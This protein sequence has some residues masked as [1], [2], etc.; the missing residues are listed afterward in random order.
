MASALAGQN[1]PQVTAMHAKGAGGSH[2]SSEPRRRIFLSF[3][4]VARYNHGS[5][6]QQPAIESTKKLQN[7]D[8]FGERLR[9][10]R[11][12]MDLSMEDFGAIIGYDKSYLSRLESGK[13]QSPSAKF[14]EAIC[15][16]YFISREWLV[17]GEGKLLPAELLE[18]ARAHRPSWAAKAMEAAEDELSTVEVLR[19]IIRDMSTLERVTKCVEILEHPAIKPGAK[20]VW[21]KALLRAAVD[22]VVKG[23]PRQATATGAQGA[24]AL[25]GDAIRKAVK[26]S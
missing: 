13:A 4:R 24:Q 3:W 9:W 23:A 10:L 21:L 25:S 26:T 1:P 5:N 22:P 6:M 15:S 11:Q 17:Q 14:I 16:K 20:S 7:K 12:T 8:A 19:L 2:Y 18:N